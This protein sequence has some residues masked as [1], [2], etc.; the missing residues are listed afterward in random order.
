VLARATSERADDRFATAE[1]MLSALE[2]ELALLGAGRES[3][4]RELA[5]KVKPLVP[6]DSVSHVLPRTA[7]VATI[8]DARTA[9]YF[10]DDR[11]ADFVD[12]VL[13]PIAAP[14]SRGRWRLWAPAV[15]SS[16]RGY[17]GH[18]RSLR[19]PQPAA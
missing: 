13:A 19:H 11:S 2:R 8:E 17:V 5:A 7:T 1:D 12:R 9:S 4:V 15:V 3:L 18:R 16:R 6:R 14:K 10:R